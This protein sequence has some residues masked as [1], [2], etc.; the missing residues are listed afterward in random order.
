MLPSF[1]SLIKSVNIPL[2][3]HAAFIKRYIRATQSFFT[4][5]K[6][7]KKIMKRLHFTN[8]FFK[9]KMLY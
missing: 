8:K 9:Y 4:N 7:S 2:D 6:L 5:K 3:R 1:E